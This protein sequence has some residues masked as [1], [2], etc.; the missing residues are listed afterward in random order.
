MASSMGSYIRRASLEAR[1]R[2]RCKAG[3]VSTGPLSFDRR[4]KTKDDALFSSTF[5]FLS[6][7]IFVVTWVVRYV[8]MLFDFNVYDL[9]GSRRVGTL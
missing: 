3:P 8:A 2:V 7:S 4:M 6:L 9:C 5:F 1:R